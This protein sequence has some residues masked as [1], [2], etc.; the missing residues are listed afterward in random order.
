MAKKA[1]D[2][3]LRGCLFCD[4]RIRFPDTAG[5]RA[6]H[7]ATPEHKANFD[8]EVFCREITSRG[9]K[10]TRKAICVGD[11]IHMCQMHA[12]LAQPGNPFWLF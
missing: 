1:K 9:T 8:R 12:R 7:D 4:G 5:G 3:G 6:A 10:C 2:D 11:G